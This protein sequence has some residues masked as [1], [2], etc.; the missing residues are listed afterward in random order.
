[1]QSAESQVNT[2]DLSELSSVQWTIVCI[3]NHNQQM[4]IFLDIYPV[5]P[6]FWRQLITEA[7]YL[8]RYISEIK[9]TIADT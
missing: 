3:T 5:I 6:G 1:M 8:Q 7:R 9:T 4:N 2:F